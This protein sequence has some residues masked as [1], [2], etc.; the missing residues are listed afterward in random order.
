MLCKDG[1]GRRR[2]SSCLGEGGVQDDVIAV[3]WPE[4]TARGPPFAAVQWRSGSGMDDGAGDQGIMFGYAGD[5]FKE[6][7]GPWWW[8]GG[9]SARGAQCACEYGTDSGCAWWTT[10]AKEVQ[11][12]LGRSQRTD[13]PTNTR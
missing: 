10:S 3:A 2:Q 7:H 1:I 12:L 11:E 5:V 4:P 9:E 6:E 8:H 13:T